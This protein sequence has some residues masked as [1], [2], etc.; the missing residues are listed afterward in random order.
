MSFSLSIHEA[1]LAFYASLY[2]GAVL[3]I[4][5]A[6]RM[7][8]TTEAIAADEL[9]VFPRR[10]VFDE[11]A[12]RDRLEASRG[13]PVTSWPGQIVSP[14]ELFANPKLLD[15]RP[16]SLVV[17]PREK[18]ATAIA[19]EFGQVGKQVWLTGD[20]DLI[21]EEAG[22]YGR[23]AAELMHKL[24]SGG[25]HA[26][27]RLIVI[28]QSL[29]RIQADVRKCISHLIAYPQGSSADLKAIRETFGGQV[30]EAVRALRKGDP[31]LLWRLG[32]A[33]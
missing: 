7:G 25:G 19:R 33:L 2:A 16:L 31:P 14:Q 11:Y 13:K 12:R 28:S 15:Q 3:A 29:M 30:A 8:K 17:A 24:S 26:G 4:I 10:V 22:R 32:D 20:M 6:P 1:T 5:G 27:M 18:D 23:F 9:G 21:C